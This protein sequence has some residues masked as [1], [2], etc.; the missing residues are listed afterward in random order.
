VFE[1]EERSRLMSYPLNT[2]SSPV[3]ATFNGTIYMVYI[4]ASN[5]AI[6]WASSS[7]GITWTDLGT[8]TTS[9]KKT[10][11]PGSDPGLVASK[12]FLVIVYANEDEEGEMYYSSWSSGNSWTDP[13]V[14]EASA[15]T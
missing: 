13:A 1:K 8:V 15:P 10:I 12:E 14:L 4:S 2:S 3:F 7:D 11:V 6:Y 5:G 9:S